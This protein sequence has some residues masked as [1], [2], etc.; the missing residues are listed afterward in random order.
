[1]IKLYQRC[2]ILSRVGVEPAL[3]FEYTI[4]GMIS[5]E[6]QAGDDSNRVPTCR[7]RPYAEKLSCVQ[8]GEHQAYY[9]LP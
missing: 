5:K 2:R 4:Y 3:E 1:M 7:S 6:R 9:L 8:T